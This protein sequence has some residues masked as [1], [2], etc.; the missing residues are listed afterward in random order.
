MGLVQ[1]LRQGVA[2][3]RGGT[4]A[5]GVP[6]GGGHWWEEGRLEGLFAPGGMSGM[7]WGRCLLVLRASPRGAHEDE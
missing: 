5:R 4:A 3:A 2:S 1:V 6:G 7:R